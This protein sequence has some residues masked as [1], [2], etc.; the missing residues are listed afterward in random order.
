MDMNIINSFAP[1]ATAGHKQAIS[2]TE[3]AME[4]EQKPKCSL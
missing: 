3:T 4:L 1:R 2:V